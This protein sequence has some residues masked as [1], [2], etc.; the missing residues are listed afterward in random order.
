MAKQFL[1]EELVLLQHSKIIQQYPILKKVITERPDLEK[2][3][4]EDLSDEEKR[5]FISREYQ[6]IMTTAELEWHS[7]DF[8]QDPPIVVGESDKYDRCELCGNTRCDT[9]YPVLNFDN[10]KKLYVGS[11]CINRF[12]S[13]LNSSVNALEKRKKALLKYSRLNNYFPG[14][15]DKFISSTSTCAED[16]EYLIVNPLY[17]ECKSC[18][19]MI[20]D[21]CEKHQAALED[22]LPEINKQITEALEKYAQLEEKTNV[23]LKTAADNPRIPDR[24]VVNDLRAKKKTNIISRIR[25]C[26]GITASTIKYIDNLEFLSKN[27][28]PTI[29][30]ITAD[31]SVHI[32]SIEERNGSV[33][34]IALTSSNNTVFLPHFSFAH[35]FGENIIQCKRISREMTLLKL[36]RIC[37]ETDIFDFIEQNKRRLSY[38][39][40]MPIAIREDTEE[41]YFRL[42]FDDTYS[43]ISVKAAINDNIAFFINSRLCNP[44]TL[45]HVL[46][47]QEHIVSKED[48][49]EIA[50]E[51]NKHLQYFK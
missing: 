47:H 6:E 25:D 19:K 2:S 34:Y 40:I 15:V 49:K 10:S 51:H 41:I 43:C 27:Y 5:Y 20:R 17:S 14:S 38:Y 13:S 28:F 36:C 31:I 8:K 11:S 22:Q 26:G 48:W 21:L 7:A 4:I 50:K 29:K 46:R 33:G 44:D 1:K 35:V 16:R 9:L 3:E 23:Y 45:C 39:K 32:A 37:E 30:K 18:F 12:L 24:K 42:D